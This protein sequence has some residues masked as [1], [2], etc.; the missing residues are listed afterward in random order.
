MGMGMDPGIAYGG[1]TANEHTVG[2]EG[3]VWNGGSNGDG[4]AQ[5]WEIGPVTASPR[6]GRSVRLCGPTSAASRRVRWSIRTAWRGT[7]SAC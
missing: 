3:T 2:P 7:G 5:D 6:T 1:S 4:F